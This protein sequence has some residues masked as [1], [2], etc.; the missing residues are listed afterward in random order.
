M[1][2]WEGERWQVIGETLDPVPA[3]VAGKVLQPLQL[4][5]I[6]HLKEHGVEALAGIGPFNRLYRLAL[7]MGFRADEWLAFEAPE[8]LTLVAGMPVAGTE[9]DRKLLERKQP[10]GCRVFGLAM[11]AAERYCRAL[12]GGGHQRYARCEG[13]GVTE[14]PIYRRGYGGASKP[15]SYGP[16]CDRCAAGLQE[17]A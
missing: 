3:P 12:P 7:V 17:V 6:E 2:F 9:H 15:R 10:R 5:I 1:S 11:I 13:C 16:S 8:R 14:Q 4:E